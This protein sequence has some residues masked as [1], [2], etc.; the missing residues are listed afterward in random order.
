MRIRNAVSLAPPILSVQQWPATPS[1]PLEH[2]LD[3]PVT[4]EGFAWPLAGPAETLITNDFV[5][6]PADSIYGFSFG[7]EVYLDTRAAW[8]SSPTLDGC[9][10][11]GKINPLD[12]VTAA[13]SGGFATS[14]PTGPITCM[15]KKNGLPLQVDTAGVCPNDPQSDNWTGPVIS[16]KAGQMLTTLDISGG[17]I[18]SYLLNDPAIELENVPLGSSTFLGF[19]IVEPCYG[20]RLEHINPGYCNPVTMLLWG[21]YFWIT[22]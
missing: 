12:P 1:E 18:T 9:H 4:T 19:G 21:C 15:F 20:F 22:V 16:P 8:Q 11:G 14:T 7:S 17:D 10:I 6:Y 5:P 13:G 3:F 2:V